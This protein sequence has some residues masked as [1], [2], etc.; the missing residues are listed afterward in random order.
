MMRR[1]LVAAAIIAGIGVAAGQVPQ[2]GLTLVSPR[3]S[4]ETYL[5]DLDQNVVRTWHGANAPSEIAY[6]LPDSSVLRPCLVPS[7]QGRGGRIQRIDI[8]DVVVWDYLFADIDFL[9]HHDILP[10]PNGNVLIV[11]WERKTVAEAVAA[12]RQ[13]VTEDMKPT[14][15]V[16]VEPVG[17][18]GGN[19]VWEWRM[20]DHIIQD[21]DPTKDNYGVVADHPELVDLNQGDPTS[22]TWI[23]VN[24]IDYNPDL[25]QIVVS[26]RAM[27]EIYVID[28]STTTAEAAGHTGGDQGRGGDILYRWGNPQIY[29]RGTESDRILFD[30]HGVNW[31]DPDLPGAGNLLMFNNGDRAA[32]N[33][34][35]S[36][37]EE[38]A[39]PV[40]SSGAYPLTIGEAFGPADPVWRYGDQPAFYSRFQGGAFRMPNGNTLISEAMEGRIFEVTSEGAIVWSHFVG[41]SVHKAPRYWTTTTGVPAT[42]L[43]VRLSTGHPNPFNPATTIAFEVE[44]EQRV[45][46]EILDLEGRHVATLADRA[47]PSGP[48]SVRWTGRDAAGRDVPS[49]VFVVRLTAPDGEESRKITLLR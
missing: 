37:V 13:S 28:H 23:H 44:R 15:L 5:I 21:A 42:P 45:M 17:S 22:A 33:N 4:I 3:T 40:D 2:E 38:I 10:M 20:W 8:N 7:A 49:G 6:M 24:A 27:S 29:D 16:E 11:A 25:D 36:S 30:V 31:I 43:S 9:Q 19:L 32:T 14:L 34:D 41:E 46:I 48:H 12:G 18:S 39:P 1:F 26:S 35:M 47:Y